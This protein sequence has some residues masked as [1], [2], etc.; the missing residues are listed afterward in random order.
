MAFITAGFV[1]RCQD[2]DHGFWVQAFGVVSGGGVE[3][4]GDDANFRDDKIDLG[5]FFVTKVP[6]FVFVAIAIFKKVAIDVSSGF[7][8]SP[9]GCRRQ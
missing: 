4:C 6:K 5:T 7:S 2:L 3:L 9:K 1:F 8:S